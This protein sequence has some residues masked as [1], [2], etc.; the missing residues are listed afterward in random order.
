MNIILGAGLTGLICA[1]LLPDSTILEAQ[2]SLPQNHQAV[3]RFRTDELAN[4]LGI[5][6]KKV[7]VQKAIWTNGMEADPSPRISHM[8]SYKVAQ[9]FSSRSIADIQTVDRY[10]APPDFQ[11]TLERRAKIMYGK[12]ICRITPTS[13]HINNH[14][15]PRIEKPII[16][17]LPMTMLNQ[18]VQ[19][20]KIPAEI[21]AGLI[22]VATCNIPD[23]NSYCSV[24]FPDYNTNVYRASITGDMLIIELIGEK[25][26]SE[27]E[28]HMVLDALGLVR[29]STATSNYSYS[30]QPIGKMNEIP[31]QAR[32]AF[33]YQQSLKYQVYSLGRFA[34]WRPK[35]MLDD[36]VDDIR[37]I[38]RLIENGNYAMNQHNQEQL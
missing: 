30:I 31:T 33:I 13:I 4:L 35:L 8:Y 25:E 1:N 37:V 12:R 11:Q 32:T 2:A 18:I 14:F 17:T 22:T 38:Q 29:N 6:F 7:K 23:C 21:N 28:E 15:E 26:L 19:G 34:T 36:L 5:P 27:S 9:K 24:Y 10:V 16:S 3:L 20:A